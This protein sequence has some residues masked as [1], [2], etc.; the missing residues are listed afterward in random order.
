MIFM[1]FSTP[2]LVINKSISSNNL[3][4]MI[5]VANKNNLV[6]RPHFKTHQSTE[7]GNWFK[8]K[9]VTS[10]TVSSI[11]MAEYFSNEW[12]DIT[13]AFPINILEIDKLNLI[14]KGNRVKILIDSLSSLK[15]LDSRL[16]ETVEVYLKIDVGYSRAGLKVEEKQKIKSIIDFCKTSKKISFLGFLAHFGDSYKSKNKMEIKN[17]F[18]KS[19]ER[20]KVLSDGFPN[21][22]ISI[23]DTPTC[24]TIKKY[25]DFINEIRPGNFIFYDLAQ[26]KIGSCEIDDIAIRMICPVVS[27]YEEREEVL[28]Y[29]G[30]VHFSK[31]RL[32]ENESDIFGYV[33]YGKVWD[34]SNKIGYIKSL[35]QEHGIVKLEKKIDLKIGDQLNVIP[36]HSCLAIDK[37][38]AFYESAKRVEIMK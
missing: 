15:I 36:V 11:S 19:I 8:E 24:S 34:V 18:H 20:I 23:G 5:G 7:I 33:Y 26:Y 13:I 2:T 31:D 14:I 16:I 25:P 37:M 9:G 3:D 22:R 35:S 12:D 1:N 4:R 27:I 32:R 17:V 29:G 30:S 38:G 10:I 28:I 21:F 6:L